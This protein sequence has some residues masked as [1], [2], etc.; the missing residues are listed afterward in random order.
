M[1]PE[2]DESLTKLSPDFSHYLADVKRGVA[3]VG[4]ARATPVV[5]GPVS[6]CHLAAYK[7]QGAIDIQR[8]ALLEKLLPI[9]SKLML[10]L[11]ALGVQEIQ[12][13]EPSLVFDDASLA[14]LFRR[15]YESSASILPANVDINICSFFED[16]GESNY[17]WLVSVPGIKTISLDFTR[18]NNLGLIEKIGFPA[19]KVLGA[20]L[21]D[22][23]NV[24]KLNPTS[25]NDTLNALSAAGVITIRVQ[26]S[27]SIYSLK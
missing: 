13:H 26:P 2:V 17:K 9:Y 22:G 5:L 25:V 23:R 14:P 12:I 27:V 7:F 16:I 20:G 6:M 10:D 8:F 1:V 19:S 3:H 11:A 15:T 4:A 24:W 18:G 21:I